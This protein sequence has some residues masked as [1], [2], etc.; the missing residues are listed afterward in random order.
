[1][2]LQISIFLPFLLWT[3]KELQ[4]VPENKNIRLKMVSFLFLSGSFSNQMFLLTISWLFSH[5]FP[6]PIQF[7]I[8]KTKI[9]V[10]EEPPYPKLTHSKTLRF[11]LTHF[12]LVHFCKNTPYIMSIVRKRQG[13]DQAVIKSQHWFKGSKTKIL[14]SYILSL[15]IV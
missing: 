15:W 9:F 8:L 12:G 5:S 4:P 10:L 7:L 1:M 2:T 6:P 13:L 14:H 11:V 3:S